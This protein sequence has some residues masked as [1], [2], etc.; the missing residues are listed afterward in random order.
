VGKKSREKLEGRIRREI[1]AALLSATPKFSLFKKIFGWPVISLIGVTLIS[2]GFASS[3]SDEYLMANILYAG[4][5]MSLLIKFILWEDTRG[6]QKPKRIFLSTAACVLAFVIFCGG[7]EINKIRKTHV[8]AKQDP[9]ETGPAIPPQ[10]RADYMESR[11]PSVPYS[12]V[13]IEH[14][15]VVSGVGASDIIAD[16][17]LL[18]KYSTHYRLIAT[19]FFIDASE[20]YRDSTDISKSGVFDIQSGLVPMRIFWN[21]KFLESLER[22][23]RGTTYVLLMVPSTMKPDDFETIREATEKGAFVLQDAGGPP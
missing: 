11:G 5:T 13:K 9:V 22:G 19:C 4:G 7:L 8:A 21:K 15:K 16:G 3:L 10:I 2:F 12:S 6:Y 20:D 18:V 17:N 23:G 1:A 14:G